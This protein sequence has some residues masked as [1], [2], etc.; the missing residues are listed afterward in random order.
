MGK[1]VIDRG[2]DANY[3]FTL[4]SSTG[5]VIFTSGKYFFKA[6]CKNGIDTVRVNATNYLKYELGTTYDGKYYFKLKGSKDHIIGR[7]C[8]YD[9]TAKRNSFV[10]IV[11]STS[12]YA[13]VIDQTHFKELQTT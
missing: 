11:K 7:S 3:Y 12:L 2:P 13:E 8:L 6:A 10:E 9:S 4:I 1:F 5:E